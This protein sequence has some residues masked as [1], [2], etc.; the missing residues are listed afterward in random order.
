MAIQTESVTRIEHCVRAP[1][2]AKCQNPAR[3]NSHP[4]KETAVFKDIIKPT[5]DGINEWYD[6]LNLLDF[7][8]G[9]F[10]AYDPTENLSGDPFWDML[11]ALL[12]VK[13][14]MDDFDEYVSTL[15]VYNKT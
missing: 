8:P 15:D 1:M 14:S 7:E 6:S 5:W 11:I 3:T 13:S 4:I 12:T 10:D 9:P 2:D